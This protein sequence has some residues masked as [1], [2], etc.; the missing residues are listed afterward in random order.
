MATVSPLKVQWTP[1]IGQAG[2]SYGQLARKLMETV[3]KGLYGIAKIMATDLRDTTPRSDKTGTHV[4]DGWSTR[5]LSDQP[6]FFQV[7]VYNADPTFDAPIPL[8]GGGETSLALILELG[9]RPHAIVPKAASF[10]SFVTREGQR[11]FTKR[12][13]HPGTK[14]YGMVATAT[15]AARAR[16]VGLLLKAAKIA[17]NVGGA[18]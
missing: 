13:L 9:S 10:L 15:E 8:A 14:P 17:S 18:P 11:V 16:A 12:V 6:D 5:V 4:A 3:N 1:G 2:Q 7:E